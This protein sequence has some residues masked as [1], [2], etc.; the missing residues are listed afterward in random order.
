MSTRSSKSRALARALESRYWKEPEARAVLAA[1]AQSGESAAVFARRHGLAPSRLLRWKAW[2]SS[3]GQ[4]PVFHPVKVIGVVG[5]T[6]SDAGATGTGDPLELVLIGG[7]RIAVRRGFDPLVLA[8][9]V[10]AVESWEC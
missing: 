3:S 6:L 10:R 7:R 8:E 9:L 2:L 1:W 5:G 4:R